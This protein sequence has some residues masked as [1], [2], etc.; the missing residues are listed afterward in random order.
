VPTKALSPVWTAVGQ[1]RSLRHA[2]PDQPFGA[3]PI[4]AKLIEDGIGLVD[5]V[6]IRFV[7]Q[8]RQRLSGAGAPCELSPVE[9]FGHDLVL[10]G[11]SI[12]EPNP[13]IQHRAAAGEKRPLW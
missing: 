13:V 4:E 9:K 5:N 1:A 6:C 11:S 10:C 7:V 3:L 2:A 8:H 12:A